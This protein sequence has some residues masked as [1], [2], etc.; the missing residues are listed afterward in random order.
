MR[1]KDLLNHGPTPVP[2]TSSTST[3]APG[4]NEVVGNES[5]QEPLRFE[6]P[7]SSRPVPAYGAA[8]TNAGFRNRS[9]EEMD[10]AHSLI[11]LGGS[12]RGAEAHSDVPA[13]CASVEGRGNPHSE[14][15][16]SG[17]ADSGSSA[18][19]PATSDST[20]L[21]SP[22]PHEHRISP[23]A[24]P[25]IH[26]P[27]LVISTRDTT[28]SY[29][30]TT[31]KGDPSSSSGDMAV[32]AL[33]DVASATTTTVAA[34]KLL[35]SN[36][37]AAV[38]LR[39]NNLP[40]NVNLTIRL[41][42]KQS[43][44]GEPSGDTP[45]DNSLDA[46]SEAP[47]NNATID[48]PLDGSSEAPPNNTPT[49]TSSDGSS[50]AP[51]NDTSTDTPLDGSSEAPS[52]QILNPKCLVSGCV[53][54]CT[55]SRKVVS[56]FFG[57][58]KKCILAIPDSFWPSYCRMHYQRVEYRLKGTFWEE[59][60]K[61]IRLMVDRLELWEREGVQVVQSWE[62][63]ARTREQNRL[64]KYNALVADAMASGGCR[65]LFSP[66]PPFLSPFPSFASKKERNIL[67]PTRTAIQ[68]IIDSA[69]YH[70]LVS[71][72]P[73]IPRICPKTGKALPPKRIAKP[74]PP[75]LVGATWT[76][77]T[78]RFGPG[79]SF[80]EIRQILDGIMTSLTSLPD[81]AGSYPEIELL[82]QLSGAY[83]KD[84]ETSKKLKVTEKAEGE[85]EGEMDEDEVAD[86]T[87]NFK[88]LNGAKR[89]KR[90]AEAKKQQ[91]QAKK[92]KTSHVH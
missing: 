42:T 30:A 74:H 61:L 3:E 80:D 83:M 39:I 16:T 62:V 22:T 71:G 35:T 58:N 86:G 49:N 60:G 21:A 38:P 91:R 15:L 14:P 50:E 76:W 68:S 87:Q 46:S 53:T 11:G 41:V 56:H 25:S 51:P 47:S 13:V 64:D 44:S 85:G 19:S 45:P 92:Q 52:N 20:L 33:A 48:T 69:A 72:P 77:L 81:R 43:I 23:P 36:S 8:T 70:N 32:T 75:L 34:P 12:A 4:S 10:A 18:T 40:S 2:P 88:P 26:I 79:K 9:L 73:I 54:T 27:T 67:N 24:G 1:V 65:S 28:S 90:E 5:T 7:P 63:K 31:P 89:R 37:L 57:R 66:F 17:N 29:L 59:Q 82:P 84:W 55:F 78:Q 6:G